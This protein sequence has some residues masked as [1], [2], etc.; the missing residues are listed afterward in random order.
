M[1]NYYY[2]GYA[3]QTARTIMVLKP[4]DVASQTRPGEVAVIHDSIGAFTI[5]PDGL[6][7]VPV[8]IDPTVA[9]ARAWDEIRLERVGILDMTAWTIM[10]DSPLSEECKAA[11][12]AYRITLNRLALDFTNAADV[13]WPEAPALV[14][15]DPPIAPAA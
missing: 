3:G 10:P 15:A 7:L 5:S 1:T 13:V 2:I 14:Y 4:A 6:S 11:Y 8:V 12:L 9:E